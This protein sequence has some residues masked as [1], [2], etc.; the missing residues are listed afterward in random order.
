MERKRK[1]KEKERIGKERAKSEKEENRGNNLGH[2]LALDGM[3]MGQ[4]IVILS[5]YL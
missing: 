4:R 1:R 3:A 2:N 5:K